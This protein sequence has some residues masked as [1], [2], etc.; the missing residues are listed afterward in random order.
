M[1][2]REVLRGSFPYGDVWDGSTYTPGVY[3]EHFSV[4]LC[5]GEPLGPLFAESVWM[6]MIHE[7]AHKL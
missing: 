3:V 6:H 1:Y 5:G 2:A 7:R 4:L